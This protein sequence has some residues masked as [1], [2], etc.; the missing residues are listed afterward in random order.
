MRLCGIT[1]IDQLHP[2]LINTRDV[3]H[4]VT[5]TDQHPYV[6]WKPKSKI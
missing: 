3:D 6:K 5:D 2:G 4:M 1:D